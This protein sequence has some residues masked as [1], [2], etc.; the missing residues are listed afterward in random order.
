MSPRRVHSPG[1]EQ[2]RKTEGRIG[3]QENLRGYRLRDGLKR[4]EARMVRAVGHRASVHNPLGVSHAF[5]LA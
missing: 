5:A 1:S 2:G 3:D 4:Q